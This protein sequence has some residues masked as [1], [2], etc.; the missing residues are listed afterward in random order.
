MKNPNTNK[1]AAVLSLLIT[2]G[3]L[4]S[5]FSGQTGAPAQTKPSTAWFADA[6]FGIFLHWG[7]YSTAAGRWNGRERTKDLWGEWIMNR[8]GISKPEYEALAK[9]FNATDFNPE[10]WA[11]VLKSSGAR[12]VVLTA[13]HHEGFAMYRSKVSPFNVVDWP[14]DFHRDAVRELG[15]A[16]RK[17]GLRFGIYYSQQVDWYRLGKGGDFNEYFN[18]VCLPQV[19]ELLSDYGP[20]SLMWFDIGLKER[21]QTDQLRALVRRLQPDALIS[22]RIGPGGGDYSGGGDN[23]V[24]QT[25]KPAPWE[26]C[27]TLN[28]HWATY[29][30]DVYQRSPTEVIRLLADIRSKGGNMLLDIGPD[31]AGRLAP[32]DVVVLRLLGKW[33]QT[34]GASIYGVGASPLAPVPWGRITAGRDNMLYLHVFEIPPCGGVVLPGVAGKIDSAWLLGDPQRKPLAVVPR[35]GIDHLIELDPNNAPASALNADDTVVAVKLSAGATYD[36]TRLADNDCR[37][38]FF[39]SSAKLVGDAGY[40]HQRLVWV[41]ADDPAVEKARYDE[42]GILNSPSSGFEWGFRTNQAG[43]FHVIVACNE[44][45]SS[46]GRILVR[47]DEQTFGAESSPCGPDVTAGSKNLFPANFHPVRLG[48]VSLPTAGLH[49]M[50]VSVQAASGSRPLVINRVTL[51][52]T[53]TTPLERSVGSDGRA[54]EPVK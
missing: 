17:E 54:L 20:V 16:V 23:E 14:R 53:R 2:V 21:S 37:N 51:V 47:I 48:T 8:A 45:N 35:G 25:V 39:P 24:P 44:P 9:R 43:D 3:I 41:D 31:E 46:P 27:M 52:P 5:G 22:P 19:S 13:K 6:G 1:R 11:G 26:S 10:E 15:D 50:K 33:L 40:K 29:P 28:H 4:T 49:R 34:F 42:I 12:Y 36:A 30:Q 38:E 18:K 32:R 7:A